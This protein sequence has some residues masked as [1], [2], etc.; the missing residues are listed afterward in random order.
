MQSAEKL[1]PLP[2]EAMAVEQ[3]TIEIEQRGLVS[4]LRTIVHNLRTP[5]T[6]EDAEVITPTQ[7]QRAER[8]ATGEF[9]AISEDDLLDIEKTRRDTLR[10]NNPSVYIDGN[11]H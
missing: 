10:K 5:I 2:P 9:P 11:L 3:Q 8:S 6:L 1:S 7:A 4:R